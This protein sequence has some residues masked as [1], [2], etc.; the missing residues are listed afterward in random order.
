MNRQV[1]SITPIFVAG[2]R[3]V[4][5]LLHD[6]GADISIKSTYN[7]T[8]LHKL[9][10]RGEAGAIAYLADKLDVDAK[11][12]RGMTPLYTA[13]MFKKHDAAKYLIQNGADANGESLGGTPLHQAVTQQDAEMVRL[14]LSLGAD[15]AVKHRQKKTP[16]EQA[17]SAGL[18]EI[19]AIIRSHGS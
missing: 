2:S 5:Q 18:D 19:V 17:E 7:E 10:Y 4:A 14:L 1:Y 8:P 9:A 16:R 15:P 3:E 6:Q 11:D 12:K 13:V